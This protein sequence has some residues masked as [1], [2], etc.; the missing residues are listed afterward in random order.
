MVLTRRFPLFFSSFPLSS[1]RRQQAAETLFP[2]DGEERRKRRPSLLVFMIFDTL[3]YQTGTL[4]T[5]VVY[6]AFSRLDPQRGKID[7]RNET[8]FSNIVTTSNLCVCV[9]LGS[10]SSSV[11]EWER[12]VLFHKLRRFFYSTCT[13]QKQERKVFL[14]ACRLLNTHIH[15]EARTIPACRWVGC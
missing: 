10:T 9:C 7:H 2:R 5:E 13:N 6:R 14:S 8:L 1:C 11:C 12:K 15:T 4:Q 3:A